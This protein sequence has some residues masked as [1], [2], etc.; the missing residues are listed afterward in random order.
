[1]AMETTQ[2][3]VLHWQAHSWPLHTLC[4]PMASLFSMVQNLARGPHTV[5]VLGLLYH[6]L[7]VHL[8]LMTDRDRGSCGCT[9]VVIKLVNTAISPCMA[10]TGSLSR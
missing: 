3:I 8:Y 1:M 4:T 5:V 7:C 2:G 6:L 9:L 10:V